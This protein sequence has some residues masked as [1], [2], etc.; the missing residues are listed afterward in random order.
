MLK[1]SD[2]IFYPLIIQ[3]MQLLNFLIF[4]KFIEKQLICN[5]ELISAIQ[6]SDS[7]I[8]F[9]ILFHYSLSQDIEYSSLV[10]TLNLFIDDNYVNIFRFVLWLKWASLVAQMVKNPPAMQETWVQYL[11]GEDPL[12]EDMGTH[13]SIHAWRI[14][15]H[16]GSWQ[17]TAHRVAKSWTGL[18][19]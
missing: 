14:P 17:A 7:V 4:K 18:S 5:I 12:E 16:R 19:N 8:L 3:Q 10:S 6:Q 9:H 15:M 1:K 13:C 11:G 2:P